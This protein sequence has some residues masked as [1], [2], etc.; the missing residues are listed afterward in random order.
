MLDI[1][2]GNGYCDHAPQKQYTNSCLL[3]QKNK[4]RIF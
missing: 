3:G 1:V 4:W 2:V